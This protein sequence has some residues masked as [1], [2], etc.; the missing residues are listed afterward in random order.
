MTDPK[1][2]YSAWLLPVDDT[3]PGVARKL[4]RRALEH[5]ELPGDLI[6]DA[7]LAVS[8]LAANLV[9]HVMSNLA[10]DDA[11]RAAGG[12]ELWLYRRRR[13]H[14]SQIVCKTFD[15]QRG[16]TRNPP[17]DPLDE[18]GRGLAIVEAIVE[19]WGC[20]LTRSMLGGPGRAI[21]GKAVWFA[22]AVPGAEPPS[23]RLTP[24]HAADEL[25]AL[26]LARGIKVVHRDAGDQVAVFMPNGPA[27]WCHDQAFSWSLDRGRTCRPFADIVDVAEQLVRIHEEHHS[28][29][30][31]PG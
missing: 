8:E 13:D 30:L 29:V 11:P 2:G 31:M 24:G 20:H 7:T 23:A 15:P 16:W 21:P 10:A 26:L 3:C 1:S 18:C 5:W 6:Y 28:G 17:P 4:L 19:E 27:V 25:R 14:H 12:P 22:M 9:Q